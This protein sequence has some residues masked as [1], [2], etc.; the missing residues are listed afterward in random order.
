MNDCLTDNSFKDVL[1]QVN[2]F[3][4]LTENPNGVSLPTDELEEDAAGD[5]EEDEEKEAPAGDPNAAAPGEP[6]ITTTAEPVNTEAA[7]IAAGKKAL[8]DQQTTTEAPAEQTYPNDLNPQ[9]QELLDKL[10]NQTLTP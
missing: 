3:R 2:S 7:E 6:S 4:D 10:A 9:H 5:L 1:T 8:E